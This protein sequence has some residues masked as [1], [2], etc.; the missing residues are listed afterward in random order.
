MKD[1]TI[2]RAG[3]V[4]TVGAAICCFTPTLVIGLGVVG[5]SASLGWLDYV[6][7]P[8]FFLSLG[9]V[10]YG[11]WRQRQAADCCPPATHSKNG[12]R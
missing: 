2:I 9:V 3:L 12:G 10:A 8:T 6:L 7:R 1:L 4:G 11:L 5:L